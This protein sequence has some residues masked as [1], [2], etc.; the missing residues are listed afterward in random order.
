M[1]VITYGTSV[2]ENAKSRRH[3][4]RRAVAMDRER[5][6]SIIDTAFGIEPEV[7]AIEVKHISRIEKA[8]SSP[9]MRDR[10]ESTSVC[11]PEIALFN[12]GYRKTRK[13]ATHVIG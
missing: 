10:H 6:E 2:K 1:T 7:V 3:A 4:R 9:S 5:I 12:A 11:L 8:C 13:D